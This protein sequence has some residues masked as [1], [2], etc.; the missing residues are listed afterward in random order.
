MTQ[1]GTIVNYFPGPDVAVCVNGNGS[2]DPV[3]AIVTRQNADGSVNLRLM[4]DG[5]DSSPAR[6][7]VVAAT[8]PV[9]GAPYWAALPA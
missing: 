7:S 1:V 6:T 8:N 3:A 2:S 5:I 9:T 4:L